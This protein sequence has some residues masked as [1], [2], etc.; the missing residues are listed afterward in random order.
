MPQR[1]F[2]YVDGFN[3]YYG[4]L[5]NTPYKWLD[6]LALARRLLRPE[7]DITAIKYFTAR[8]LP[9]P[10]DPEKPTRQQIYLRALK[11]IGTEIILGRYLSHT[12]SMHLASPLPDGST[13]VQVIKTEEKGSDVNLACHLLLDAA[14][15]RFDCA[16]AIT[17]DS[18]LTAPVQMAVREFGKKVGVV[19]PQHKASQ[20][21]RDS[22]TFYKHIHRGALAASQFP[23]H[24]TDARGPF[25]K[26]ASW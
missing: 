25:S 16:L 7:N 17:G 14:R 23:P 15:D 22:A 21:L 3:L 8:I 10:D 26:P 12:V 9:R 20:I 13:S 5:R 1:T 18:D 6:L 2:V 24:L 11:T 4:S 19:N